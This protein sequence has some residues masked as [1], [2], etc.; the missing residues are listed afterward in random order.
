MIKDFFVIAYE[1]IKNRKLRSWL[2]MIGI[3][4][5]IAMVV[6]LIST[7]EGMQ[8]AI[9]EQFSTIGAD[10]ITIQPGA[11]MMS[12]GGADSS[13]SLTEKDFKA[14]E[15]TRGVDIVGGMNFKSAQIEYNDEFKYGIIIGMPTDASKEL[16]EDVFIEIERGRDIKAG[17][18]YKVMLGYNYQF[19]ELVFKKA[20]GLRD[21]LIIN[22]QKFKVV[23]FMKK[24][25]NP[26]D[27]KNIYITME[28]FRDFFDDPENYNYIMARAKKGTAPQTV[29]DAIIDKLRSTRDVD[30]GKEDFTVQTMDEMMESFGDILDIVQIVLLGIVSI[31]LVVGGVGVMNTMYTAVL[32]RTRE[33]GLMKAIGARNSSVLLLFVIES[34]IYG[35]VGGAIGIV[36][37]LLMSFGIAAAAAPIIGEGLFNVSVKLWLVLGAL[38]FSFIIGCAAG[39][40]PSYQASKLKPV[41]SLRYE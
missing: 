31:S 2:T 30:K 40:A 19:P 16:F 12:T 22:G 9:E 33:I 29:A 5:G 13:S 1:N 18:K 37:G 23:G 35:L 39:I 28:T 4:I 26:E 38:A 27:D 3:F 10:V 14:I 7:G 32:E 17:D 24:V 15:R 25:G 41:D 20:I 11:G 6:A 34:G 8:D 36:L 21:S